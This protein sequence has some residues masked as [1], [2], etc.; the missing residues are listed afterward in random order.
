MQDRIEE[1]FALIY[2][3]SLG[4]PIAVYSRFLGV[5]IGPVGFAMASFI[6]Y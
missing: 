2:K 5:D 6:V 3:I 1:L 4:C